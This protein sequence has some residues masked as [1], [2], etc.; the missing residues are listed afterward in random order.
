M[1]PFYSII[2]KI[3]A[4]EQVSKVSGL[5]GSSKAMFLTGLFEKSGQS[6]FVITPDSETADT[7]LTDLRFFSRLSAS[8]PAIFSFPCWE[9]LPYDTI[10]P[11]TEITHVRMSGYRALLS[12]R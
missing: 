7:L 11:H 12:G 6:I 5:W 1:Y 9:I 3:T 10:P 8:H 2:T 4:G